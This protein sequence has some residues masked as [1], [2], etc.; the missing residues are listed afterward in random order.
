M[1][2]VACEEWGGVARIIASFYHLDVT[3]AAE[4]GSGVS[5]RM[6]ES[7]AG[8]EEVIYSNMITNEISKSPSNSIYIYHNLLTSLNDSEMINQKF[9]RPLTNHWYFPFIL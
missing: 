1:K 5:V 2:D 3:E 7:V 6:L 8:D 4:F 9:V